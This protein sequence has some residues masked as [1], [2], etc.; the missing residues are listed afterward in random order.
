MSDSMP[1]AP[2]RAG[3]LRLTP[4]QRFDARR[5]AMLGFA[6]LVPV[7][8]GAMR[9]T[10]I[11]DGDL[12]DESYWMRHALGVSVHVL[13]AMVF[14]FAGALQFAPGLR[15]ARP[16]LHRR[17]G[18]LL[19][20]AGILSAASGFLLRLL[21]E[22]PGTQGFLIGLVQMPMAALWIAFLWLGVRSIRR[23]EVRRHG[24]WML[25]AYALGLSA[26]T[27]FVLLVPFLLLG[28]MPTG[29]PGALYLAL[30]GLVNLGIAER[31]IHRRPGSGGIRG[32]SAPAA[33]A[34]PGPSNTIGLD[35]I[36][37]IPARRTSGASAA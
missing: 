11:A 14:A 28:A 15:R 20:P 37:G 16:G 3:A 23:G 5:L 35:D 9:L 1:P 32:E 13:G 18:R 10:A 4:G 21:Y 7:V 29:V 24:A 22:E 2:Q 19:V 6:A 12:P 27:Q 8:A 26:S 34:I 36:L 25:R 30:G 17:L 31:L 33:R